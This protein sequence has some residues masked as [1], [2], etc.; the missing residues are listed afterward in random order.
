M[1]SR[2]MLTKM[3]FCNDRRMKWAWKKLEE[4]KRTFEN[5]WSGEEMKEFTKNTLFEIKEVYNQYETQIKNAWEDNS[6]EMDQYYSFT[7]YIQTYPK[8][9]FMDKAHSRGLERNEEINHKDNYGR[10]I[11]NLWLQLDVEREKCACDAC[12]FGEYCKIGCKDEKCVQD[13]KS[14]AYR[15]QCALDKECEK[16]QRQRM[17][18]KSYRTCRFCQ[19]NIPKDEFEKVKSSYEHT[20]TKKHMEPCARKHGFFTIRRYLHNLDDN[21]FEDPEDFHD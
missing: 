8:L 17:F 5:S 12:A 6:I 10:L 14:G 11:E 4:I 7:Y 9:D 1:I 13:I 2:M 19:K 15:H 18:K 3:L 20:F 21:N 16:I